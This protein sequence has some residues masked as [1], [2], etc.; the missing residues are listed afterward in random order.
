MEEIRKYAIAL[1][2]LIYKLQKEGL[3]FEWALDE[4]LA[5][6]AR[7][8]NIDEGDARLL[9]EIIF[10]RL[11]NEAFKKNDPIPE[12]DEGKMGEIAYAY[13]QWIMRRDGIRLKADLRRRVGSTA[14]DIGISTDEMVEFTKIL[15]REGFDL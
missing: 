2:V 3:R 10:K 14:K 13:L 6:M 12:M 8:M 7:D 5:Q 11:L 15:V 1:L 9:A 4:R